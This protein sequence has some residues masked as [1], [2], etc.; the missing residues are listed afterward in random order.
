M[1]KMIKA[2]ICFVSILILNADINA[3]TITSSPTGS[4]SSTGTWVGGVVPLATDTVVIAASTNVTVG[5]NTTVK[6]LTVNNDGYLTI[7]SNKTL[8]ITGGNLTVD[9]LINGAGAL[10]LNTAGCLLSG[11][12]SIENTGTF[13]AVQNVTI[14]STT[15]LI[16]SGGSFTINDHVIV[17]NNGSL[18][19][20]GAVSGVNG[21]ANAQFVNAANAYISVGTTLMN[22]GLLNASA[23]GNTVDYSSTA[24]QT[25]YATTYHHL[26][27][28]GAG[29]KKLSAAI[30]INGNLTCTAPFNPANNDFSVAGDFSNSNTFSYGTGTVTLNGTSNQLL[31]LSVTAAQSFYNLVINKL[32]G[33][34]NIGSNMIVRNALTM[35]SGNIDNT[36]FTMTLGTATSARGTLNY[37][38]GTIIGTFERWFATSSTGTTFLYP[39][40]SL[41]NYRPVNIAF[42]NIATAGKLAYTF[43]TTPPENAGLP[44]TAAGITSYNNFNDGQWIATGN[45]LVST[46]YNLTLDGNGFTAFPFTANTRILTNTSGNWVAN[47][48]HGTQ[49]NTVISRT[50]ITGVTGSFAIASDNNCTLPSLLTLSGTSLP[51]KNT[52]VSYSV[53]NSVESTYAWTIPVGAS[54]SGSTTTNTISVVYG[55]TTGSGVI[56]VKE[57]NSCGQGPLI[58]QIV[59]VGPVAPTLI[60]GYAKVAEGN[61][62]I[63]Y[64]V[65]SIP[66]YS[67]TWSI[68]NGTIVSGQSKGRI[69]VDFA[70]QGTSTLNVIALGCSVFA[71]MVSKTINVAK[72]LVST[73]TIG[74]IDDPAIW[75]DAVVTSNSN[76]L[77]NAGAVVT[78]QS[79]STITSVSSLTIEEGATLVLNK[80]FTVSGNFVLNGTLNTNGFNLVISGADKYIRGTG[81]VIN[82]GTISITGGNKMITSDANLTISGNVSVDANSIAVTN[83]GQVLIQG[84]LTRSSSSTSRSWVNNANSTLTVNG[85]V[86][87]NT[88]STGANATLTVGGN[89]TSNP[90]VTG[91]ASTTTVTGT[92]ATVTAGTDAILNLVGNVTTYVAGINATLNLSGTIVTTCTATAAGN[93]V[94]Y[95]GASPTVKATTYH[96]LHVAGSTMASLS[97]NTTVNGD[98]NLKNAA[99]LSLGTRTITLKGNFVSTS[100]AT[101]PMVSGTGTLFLTGITEQN[102]S[103]ATPLS[104]YNMTINKA[105]GDVHLN[106]NTNIANS[107][108]LTLG[109]VDLNGFT[110]NLATTG[111]LVSESETSRVKG[112]T[113]SIVATRNVGTNVADLNIAGLGAILTTTTIGMGDVEV[114]RNHSSFGSGDNQTPH[115]SYQI[116][117]TVNTGLNTTFRATYLTAEIPVGALFPS[118]IYKSTGGDFFDPTGTGTISTGANYVQL[119]GIS[120]FS[121]W[122]PGGPFA[123]SNPLPVTMAT[124]TATRNSSLI[125]LHWTTTMERDNKEFVIERSFDGENFE[126]LGT[127]AGFGTTNNTSNYHYN[128]LNASEAGMFFRLKQI[129]FDGEIAYSKVIVVSSLAQAEENNALN[130]AEFSIFPNPVSSNEIFLEFNNSDKQTVVVKIHDASEKVHYTEEIDIEGTGVT[131]LFLVPSQTLSRGVYYVT[132]QT[133]TKI[134]A[135]KL[136]VE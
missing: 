68:S 81:T 123:P 26:S 58:S 31:T 54:I 16:K 55:A 69:T 40:G 3:T 56:T 131:K 87:I 17:T 72:V 83:N 35:T 65:D 115:R 78:V 133:L 110:I 75:Q 96:H 82:G 1:R 13:K 108:T 100:T 71:P 88:F 134:K 6:K 15:T 89:V 29:T 97:A 122:V 80:N 60:Q 125:V 10:S 59:H 95:N 28:S 135:L 101:S 117:P 8:T 21:A 62:G 103:S 39:V 107:L 30:A 27:L 20:Y 132:I 11:S 14:P 53:S 42:A 114:T 34:V 24:T 105:S 109:D 4:W 25:I 66:G 9:G 64:Y 106:V 121:R 113:G 36:G 93:M 94:N 70:S 43:T 57:T 12:G 116:T 44:L 41:T 37:T 61:Q 38:S 49:V 73:D 118:K 63:P 124:F 92:T 67:Y 33:I 46:N 32:S 99:S 5:A 128:V 90:F 126:A 74:D 102:I 19:V 51:C 111:T 104:L 127:V 91:N 76:I 129:D 120:S 112:A 86:A 22:T 130:D 48:T 136:V 50:A 84:D 47:G 23:I 52:I 79:K 119:S 98:F 77:I 18:T 85:N 45:S 7:L 2:L